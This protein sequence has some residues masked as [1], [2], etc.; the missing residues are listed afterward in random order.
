MADS[1]G[2]AVQATPQPIQPSPQAIP[3]GALPAPGITTVPQSNLAVGIAMGTL[4]GLLAATLYAVI[5]IVAE[6]EFAVL[7]LLIGFGIAFGFSRFGHTRGIVPGVIAAVIA[8]V[9]FFVAIFVE[10]AGSIAK[11]FE[12]S[13]VDGLRA[14]VESP[15]DVVSIYFSDALSY[16]FLAITV[17][18]AFYYANGGKA[19]KAE[20]AAL[21]QPQPAITNESLN[22]AQNETPNGA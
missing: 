2:D 3:T 10:A 18:F 13:F 19:A 8:A 12:A 6:R 20:K 9:L 16:L 22:E 11:Y 15:G 5:A 1:E 4:F 14:A 17:G 7:A 21:A